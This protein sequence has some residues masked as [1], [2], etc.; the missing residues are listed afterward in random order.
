MTDKEMAD[1]LKDITIVTDTREQKNS[2]ILSFLDEH[3]VPHV[4]QKLDTADY[5]FILPHYPDLGFDKSVLIEKKN[6]LT[7]IAGNFT[8][9]RE[10]FKREFD[11][12]GDAHIHLVIEDATW[13][14]VRNKSWRSEFS[15]AAMTASLLT[16][17]IR[18][19]CPIWFVGVDESPKLIY[20][21]IKYEVFEKLK[22]I[23]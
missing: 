2:H 7:E 20:D 1:I 17:Q 15:S 14:K 11:R 23:P 16:W 19:H 12:V 21:I 5:S 4:T 3:C 22:N 6:S 18:Y 13:R 8:K 10:R 9:D